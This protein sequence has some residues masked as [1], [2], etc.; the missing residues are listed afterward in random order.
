MKSFIDSEMNQINQVKPFDKRVFLTDTEYTLVYLFYCNSSI[1]MT[2]FI[3][4]P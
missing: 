1:F 2:F 4:N 3:I